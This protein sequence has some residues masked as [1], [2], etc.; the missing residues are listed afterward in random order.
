M[1]TTKSVSCNTVVKDI[2]EFC[3]GRNIFLTCTYI[4]GKDN[5]IADAA[6]RKEYKQGEWMLSKE[7]FCRAVSHFKFEP[8]IDAF[9]T[10]ANTQLE[11][12]SSRYPDPYATQVDAFSYNWLSY[13]PYLFPPFSLINSVLQKVRVDKAVALGVFPRWK[14]QAWWPQLMEMVV[15]EPL[16][17]PP[18]PGN[19][20]LPNRREE[21]HPLQK[22]LELCI[23]IVSGEDTGRRVIQTRL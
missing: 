19:L 10:R 3:F 16:I 20:L 22:K 14:T 5:V 21:L 13:R 1:G 11:V 18:G 7:L 9:A 15:G 12:Y 2:W 4:P 6:S 8:D 23:C 17:I